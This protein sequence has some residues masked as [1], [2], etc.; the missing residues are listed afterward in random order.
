MNKNDES[1][2]KANVIDQRLMNH[3]NHAIQLVWE[4]YMNEL[5]EEGLNS[6]GERRN[7]LCELT[8][9]E[10]NDMIEMGETFLEE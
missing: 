2:E 9:I 5:F 10:L 7:Y 3:V 1:L 4:G 6:I 8:E